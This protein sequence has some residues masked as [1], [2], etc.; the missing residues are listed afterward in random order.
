MMRNFRDLD[1]WKKSRLLLLV[2]Y[3]TNK[4]KNEDA[5]DTFIYEMKKHSIA[6]ISALYKVFTSQNKDDI[7]RYSNQAL[8]S[9]RCIESKIKTENKRIILNEGLRSLS[10]TLIQEIKAGIYLIRKNS[11]HTHRFCPRIKKMNQK[12][13]TC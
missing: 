9:I 3:N 8:D 13:F 12:V 10:L 5:P 1:I 7:H 6:F 11:F 4:D 2:L